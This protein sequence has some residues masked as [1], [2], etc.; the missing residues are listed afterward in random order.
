MENAAYSEE[1]KIF[2]DS[3]ELDLLKEFLE[4]KDLNTDFYFYCKA[5]FDEYLSVKDLNEV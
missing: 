3:N 4:K 5:E 2:H 1:F